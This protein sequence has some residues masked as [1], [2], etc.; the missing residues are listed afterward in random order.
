[1]SNLASS[2][3]KSVEAYFN[4]MRDANKALMEAER[5]VVGIHTSRDIKADAKPALDAVDRGS[6]YVNSAPRISPE[7]EEYRT[8]LADL[9]NEQKSILSELAQSDLRDLRPIDE[10]EEVWIKRYNH[11]VSDYSKWLPGFLKEH[12]YELNGGQR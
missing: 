3:G 10:K 7:T 9:L 4:N 2:P 11:F 12:G 6:R 8:R 1:M 5:F